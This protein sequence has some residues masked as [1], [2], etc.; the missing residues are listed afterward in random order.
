MMTAPWWR[1]IAFTGTRPAKSIT[2]YRHVTR[3]QRWCHGFGRIIT[4]ALKA[5][6]SFGWHLSSITRLAVKGSSSVTA[7]ARDWLDKVK[8]ASLARAARFRGCCDAGSCVVRAAQH[9]W[10]GDGQWHVRLETGTDCFEPARSYNPLALA[11]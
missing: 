6:T 1:N 8:R 5:P 11:Y 10:C 9:R 2:R 3:R 4:A 7:P